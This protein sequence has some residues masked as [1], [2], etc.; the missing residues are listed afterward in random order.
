MLSAVHLVPAMKRGEPLV[1]TIVGG[2]ASAH[3]LIPF[4]S[5]VGHRVQLLTRRPGQWSSEVA[6]ELQSIDGELEETF[7]GSLARVSD[8]PAEVVPG[9]DLVVLCMPV[10]KYRIALHH[11]APHLRRDGEVFVGTIYGQAGFNWMVREIE[12]EHGLDN[13]VTFAVGLIPWICRVRH[14]GSVGITYGSKEV[15]VAAVSPR[16]RFEALDEAFFDAI[17]ARWLGKG[18]FRPS[19]SFLSLTLSVDNQIIHPSR[20]YGLFRRYGGRWQSEEEIP[21]FYR[22]FDEV[23]A[24]AL[25]ALDA[26]YSKVREAIRARFPDRSFAYMLDYLAL[27]RLSYQSENTDIRESFT[28]SQTLGAIKPPT[29]RLPDG[30][31]GIDTDH[32]FFTDDVSYGVCIAKWLAQELGIAVPTMDA[33]IEWVQELTGESYIEHGELL[34]DGESLARPFRSGIPPVYGMRTVEEVVEE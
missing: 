2:G 14:Y 5:G 12:R 32:R 29:K 15:N 21:Y 9:S 23:S 8:D 1:V 11:L 34:V 28:S 30:S 18:A 20:C 31:W 25:R 24:E 17:C 3:V 33:I 22:D 6:L 10:C 27:E 13:L 26:D 16:D 4:L 19:D 7:R